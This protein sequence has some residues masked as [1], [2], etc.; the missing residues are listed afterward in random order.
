MK[1][2]LQNIGDSK[3]RTVSGFKV[4]IS[5]FDR[6]ILVLQAPMG[7]NAKEKAMFNEFVY[8]NKKLYHAKTEEKL[9]R[10]LTNFINR[11]QTEMRGVSD[12]E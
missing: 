2:K 11:W 8:K 3:I 4:K 5:K 10:N 1:N 9:I 7:K 6:D 12:R